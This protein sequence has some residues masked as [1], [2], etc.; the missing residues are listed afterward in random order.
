MVLIIQCLCGPKRHCIMGAAYDTA[1]R[2]G[3]DV[4]EELH[5]VIKLMI[6]TGAINK[7]CGICEAPTS[8]WFYE[9]AA[10]RFTS[11]EEALPI[12]IR[13]EEE[14]RRRATR[15][16]IDGFRAHAKDN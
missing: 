11:M 8:E 4:K 1:D 6:A 7:W 12:L 2:D 15:P 14:Q 13:A 5:D 10:S 9:T 16:T 3:C